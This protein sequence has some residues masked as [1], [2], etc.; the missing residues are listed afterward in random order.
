MPIAVY[1][2]RVVQRCVPDKVVLEPADDLGPGDETTVGRCDGFLIG[3]LPHHHRPAK[4]WLFPFQSGRIEGAVDDVQVDAISFVLAK[5]D[6]E[7]A[8]QVGRLQEGFLPLGVTRVEVDADGDH[9]EFAG[10]WL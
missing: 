10:A 3:P 8:Q 1:M 7:V 2:G 6:A 5:I 4:R 9:C